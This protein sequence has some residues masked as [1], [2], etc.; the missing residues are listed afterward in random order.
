MLPTRLT[1]LAAVAVA[2]T[3]TLAAC[4]G[5]DDGGS[6]DEADI[7]EA[8]E[9]SATSNDPSQLHRAPD[10]GVHGADGVRHGT[11]GDRVLRGCRETTTRPTASRSSN[12]EVD[13]DAAT[14]EAAVTGGGLDGQTLGL[15]LVKEDDQWKLDSF[16]EFVDVRQGGVH[17]GDRRGRLALT[18]SRRPRWSSASN[19]S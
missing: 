15:S 8:I 11:R 5:D 7:T 10:P 4:G 3:L 17:G 9:E 1:I 19:S 16:D 6:D 14:A 13:G 12:I 18:P 2:A